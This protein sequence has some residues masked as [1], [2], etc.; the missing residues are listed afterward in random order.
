MTRI[1]QTIIWSVCEHSDEQVSNC[2][3][4]PGDKTLQSCNLIWVSLISTSLKHSTARGTE[5]SSAASDGAR[6][7]PDMNPNVWPPPRPLP[8]MM[9]RHYDSWSSDSRH[10]SL[11]TRVAARQDCC[12]AQQEQGA[13]TPSG[14]VRTTVR[15][16]DVEVDRIKIGG[17]G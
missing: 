1:S 6:L 11:V 3:L 4:R 17:G 16:Q 7:T 13:C 2:Q 5:S 12:W 10:I 15:R 8:L 9:P 14:P